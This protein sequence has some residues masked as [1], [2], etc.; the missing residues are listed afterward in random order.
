[1]GCDGAHSTVREILHL[2][3]E[4][5]TYPEHLVLADVHLEGD[6]P[7]GVT[8]IWLNDEGLLS[9]IPFR[10]PGLWRLM[11]VVTP[12]AHGSVPQ[13]SVEVFQRLLARRAGDTTTRLGEP[14]WLSNF[15]VHHRM[16]PRYRKGRVFVAGDAAHIHSPA[17]GQG[18]NTGIQDTYNLAWKLALVVNGTAPEALLDTY[19]AERLPVARKVLQETDANQRFGI[20]HG[21]MA[22][23]LRNHI[24]FPVLSV[25]ALRDRFIEFA[26]RRGTEFDINYRR[27]R[28]SEQHDHFGSG[29]EAGDRAPDGRCSNSPGLRPRCLPNSAGPS[30]GCCCSKAQQ[31]TRT[32]QS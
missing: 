30:F 27:S 19:E 6:L 15:M 4:G 20:S 11:A 18:M 31:G 22:E 28:L 23:F 21:R 5:E 13:A 24:V 16:V 9:G 2:P 29:P 3:L 17:G 14:V 10:E 8:I 25:P 26:L 32:L 7:E 12:D 1:V